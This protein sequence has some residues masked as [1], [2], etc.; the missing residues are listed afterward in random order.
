MK[1]LLW[2]KADLL[3]T[4]HLGRFYRRGSFRIVDIIMQRYLS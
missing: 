3:L 2:G 1:W 4:P